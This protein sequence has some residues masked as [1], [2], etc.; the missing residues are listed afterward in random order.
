MQKVTEPREMMG[1][2]SDD[3]DETESCRDRVR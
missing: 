3:D 2:D 1:I